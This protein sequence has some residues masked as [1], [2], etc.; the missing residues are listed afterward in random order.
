MDFFQKLILNHVLAEPGVVAVISVLVSKI[1]MVILFALRYFDA[2]TIKD[3]LDRLDEIIKAEVDKEAALTA[4]VA[5]RAAARAAN[6][7]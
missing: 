4:L 3:E 1:D 5:Q 6:T 2:Q 7:Q